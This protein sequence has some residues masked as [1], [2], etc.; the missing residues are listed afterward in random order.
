[1]LRLALELAR[2]RRAAA[3]ATFVALFSA[4]ALIT[5]CGL[6]LQTGLSGTVAPERYAAAPII[7]SGDQNAHGTKSKNGKNKIKS[8]PLSERVWVAE[9]V[10]GTIRSLPSVH[11]VVT[12]V[13]FPA[14]LL[15][16]GQ[17]VTRPHGE[18]SLGHGWESAP[19]TPFTLRAGRAP[20][21]SGE[22]VI[23]AA[24][25]DRNNVHVGSTVIVQTTTAP[26][27]YHVVGIVA[28]PR[29]SNGLPS[30]SA[31]FFSS[32]DAGVLAGHTGLYSALGVWPARGAAPSTVAASVRRAGQRR[33]GQRTYRSRS[34]LRGISP[35]QRHEGPVD[36]RCRRPRRRVA[37]GRDARPRSH[38][39]TDH[40]AQTSR[41]RSPSGSRF[42][43]ATAP[44]A[45]RSGSAR[46]GGRCECARLFSRRSRGSV[47]ARPAGRGRRGP[48]EPANG[49]R[50]IS[51]LRCHRP[52]DARGLDRCTSCQSARGRG[53]DR[54]SRSPR[55]K[56]RRNGSAS[57]APLPAHCYSLSGSHSWPCC[58]TSTRS[59]PRRQSAFSPAW[60]GSPRSRC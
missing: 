22:V 20:T 7:V 42:D 43:P 4:A 60:S 24:L 18:P 51:L 1:M 54:R 40:R 50:P 29:Q 2:H 57:L 33:A 10:A 8:K 5:G 19:L 56:S 48:S 49:S 9:D 31:I 13:T 41:A 44:F 21:S 26:Q 39:R 58:D 53:F 15:V 32:P 17:P 23:D 46:R 55:L 25:A 3:I 37:A 47:V 12:E 35:D 14:S 16:H 27:P 34:W 6:L 11:A 30:Q 52:H 59:P 38:H 36:Q 45:R 28:P